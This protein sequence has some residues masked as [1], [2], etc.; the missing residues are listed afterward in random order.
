MTWRSGEH[1]GTFFCV[2]THTLSL[3]RT[4]M[5]VTPLDLTA[6]NAYSVRSSH[7]RR[8]NQAA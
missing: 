2:T 1:T 5:L 4:A 6:L 8:C 7:M 3:P